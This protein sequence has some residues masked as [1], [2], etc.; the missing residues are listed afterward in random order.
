MQ[1]KALIQEFL[2]NLCNKDFANANESLQKA[3]NAKVKNVVREIAHQS[4]EKA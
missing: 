1:D 3:V 2:K 4:K